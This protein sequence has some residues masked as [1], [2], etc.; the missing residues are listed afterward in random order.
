V[1]FSALFIQRPVATT[2]VMIGILCFG[3]IG[4]TLL[5]VSDIPN[6]DY[7]TIS[8]NAS[9]PGASPETMASSV[10]TPLE[11]QFSTIPG[12]DVMTSSSSQGSTSITL[13]FTLDRDIDDA[14]QD[15]NAA[16]AQVQ[17]R[18]PTGIN[19]PSYQKVNPADSPILFM[20]L[21]SKLMPLSG[22][23]EYA[24]SFLAQRLSMVKGVAQV[25]VWG[26]QKRAVRLQLDPHALASLG[27]DSS[28]W[29]APSRR[30]T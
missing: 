26:A 12:V 3:A 6:V 29:R 5:P 14:A 16:I 22:L 21:T 18:L 11:K 24:E 9:L 1:N 20:T 10:A 25:S 8:V 2:L 23:N 30:G 13:Q 7:P 17:R 4:Y 27:V 15:V 19:P 28:R